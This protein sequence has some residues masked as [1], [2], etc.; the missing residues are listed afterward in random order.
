[1]PYIKSN[2]HTHTNYCDGDDSM[3]NM[4]KGAIACG[5]DTLGFSFHSY[6]AFD[7]SYCIRDYYAYIREYEILKRKYAG[8]IHLLNGVELD[9]FGERPS[10]CD[11][12]IG[13]VHYLEVKPGK[14]LP[15]DI[16]ER[17]F[18]KTTERIYHGDAL[19]A[20]E[21]YYAEVADMVKTLQPDIVG[22]F[23]LITRFNGN[24]RFFDENSDRYRRAAL[25]AIE[26]LPEGAV[27]E[28][29]LGRL[30][31]GEGDIY[32]SEKLI[33]ALRE[34]GCRFMLSSDAHQAS[35]IGFEFDETCKR[36]KKLGIKSLVRYKGSE[37]VEEAL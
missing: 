24:G 4:I 14:Y 36:L 28:I 19:S 18:A 1:M 34:R 17:G 20:A 9:Y 29:N 23:D 7:P 25:G 10:V 22:H 35:A 26:A 6:T 27:V 37:L 12:V 11:F 33:P 5:M 30:Y 31:R 15:I 21:A 13:S 2:V 16:S 8:S 3:E 32:P